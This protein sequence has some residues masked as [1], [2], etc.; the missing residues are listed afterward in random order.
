[1]IGRL[2]WWCVSRL[3]GLPCLLA[4]V[5]PSWRESENVERD[6]RRGE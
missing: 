5:P 6:P 3:L 4:P 1:M 2:F